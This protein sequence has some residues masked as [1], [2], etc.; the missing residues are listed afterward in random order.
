MKNKLPIY[1]VAYGDRFLLSAHRTEEEAL[2][3]RGKADAYIISF[4][5]GTLVLR[6]HT[7][8]TQAGD[9]LVYRDAVPWLQ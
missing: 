8:Y 9:P 5:P 3:W 4:Q 7:W 1:F 2:Q 6:G